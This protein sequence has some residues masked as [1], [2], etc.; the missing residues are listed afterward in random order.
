[1]KNLVLA[2]ALVAATPAL[3]EEHVVYE[4]QG[5]LVVLHTGQTSGCEIAVARPEADGLLL[6][7]WEDGDHWFGF[8]LHRQTPGT[9]PRDFYFAIDGSPESI[10]LD[11]GQQWENGSAV[12]ETW[13]HHDR[14]LGYIEKMLGADVIT[15]DWNTGRTSVIHMRDFR[16]GLPH[17]AA[18]LKGLTSD[19]A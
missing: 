10:T 17:F 9:T 16:E 1:M 12:G 3:A 18:C 2:A 8:Y 13:V 14:M 4:G 6:K 11:Y 7:T 19:P 5:V 15:I